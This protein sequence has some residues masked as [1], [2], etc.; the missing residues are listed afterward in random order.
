VI[1][2]IVLL[3]SSGDLPDLRG[4]R[5]FRWPWVHPAGA[6]VAAHRHGSV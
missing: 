6:E 5:P 3:R 2:F 1:V 4:R